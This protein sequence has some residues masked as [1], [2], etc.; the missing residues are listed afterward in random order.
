MK[1]VVFSVLFDLVVYGWNFFEML[2]FLFWL[3][4]LQFR[5]IFVVCLFFY[6]V[7]LFDLCLSINVV[8]FF[9]VVLLEVS[10]KFG[11]LG[12]LLDDVMVVSLEEKDE[13]I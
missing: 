10:G 11:V 13:L 2:N 6:V 12:V 1:I 4:F 9:F 7:F 8:S 3:C 5:W